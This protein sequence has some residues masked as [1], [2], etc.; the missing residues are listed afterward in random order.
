MSKAKWH[1]ETITFGHPIESVPLRIVS[2]GAMANAAVADGRLIP[3]LLV[4]TSSRPDI[5]NFIKV[6]KY[7]APGD[8]KSRWAK[9]SKKQNTVNLILFFERPS[10]CIAV[11]EFD[12]LK[13]GGI[14]DQIVLNEALYLRWAK[15]GERFLSTFDRE[16][17][18]VEVPS[19]HFQPEWNKMLFK[20]LETDGRRQGMSRKQAK[21]YSSGV[22]KEWREFGEMRKK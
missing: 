10:K 3:V 21:E 15:E 18:L 7:I 4:D 5:E 17:I 22:I 8:A 6:H 12:I 16:T 13:F 9:L 11:L 1:S 20:A 19:K 2:D 14:V